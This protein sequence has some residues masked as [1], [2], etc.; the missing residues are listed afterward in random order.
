MI[1][2]SDIIEI[3]T[4]TKTHGIKGELNALLDDGTEIMQHVS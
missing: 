3:G 1:L 4:F 2:S